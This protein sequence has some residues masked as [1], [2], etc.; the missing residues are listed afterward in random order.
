MMFF[1]SYRKKLGVLFLLIALVP[2][3]LFGVS[4]NNKVNKH[5]I[6][7][8]ITVKT[9]SV[10]NEAEKLDIW[11][12]INEEKIKD[13]SGNYSFITHLVSYADNNEKVTAYLSSQLTSSKE[14]QN[15]HITMQNGTEYTSTGKLSE[16]D[17]RLSNWY[18]NAYLSKDIVWSVLDSGTS[19][20]KLIVTASVPLFDDI[21]EIE[22]VLAADFDFSVILNGIKDI[23]INKNSVTYIVD[24][25]N[26]PLKVFGKELPISKKDNDKFEKGI[27]KLSSQ[28]R[29][30]RNGNTN[31]ELG[32]EYLVFYS[33]LPSINWR[34]ISFVPKIDFYLSLMIIG[35]YIAI[36][37]II[38]ISIVIIMSIL[39]SKTFS[40]P[41]EKLKDGAIEIRN[42]NY[43]YRIDVENKDEFGDVAQAF[44][45]MALRLKQSYASLNDSNEALTRNNE[46]LQEI[47]LELEASYEQLK[48]TTD[49]LNDS[50]TKYRL[51]I[52]NMY[53]LVW[54]VDNELNITFINDQVYNIFKLQ[55]NEVLGKKLI[56]F[57][58]LYV[59]YNGNLEDD[60]KKKDY[61]NKEITVLDKHGK[62]V[63]AEITT[64]RMQEY[65]NFI[66]VQGVVRDITERKS[67]E[68]NILKRNEELSVINKISRSISS[69][70]NAERLLQIAADD[71]ARL[72]NISV[73]TIRLVSEHNALKLMAHSGELADLVSF[74]DIPI[75]EDISGEVVKTG[76]ILISDVRDPKTK[77]KHNRK[78]IESNKIYFTSMLPIKSR[79]KV[80]GVINVGGINKLAKS[81]F[82]ILASITNQIAMK[83]ENIQLYEGLKD[84]YFKTIETLAAAIEAKDEYTQGHSSRV[85]RYSIMI[86]ESLGLSK[87]YCE[88]IEVAGI[89]HDIGKIGIS[90]DIL[91][92]PGRL[93]EYE[94][95]MITKHPMI[96]SKILENVG[97]SE[98]IM[99]AIKYH[100]R[101]YDLKGYPKQIELEELPLEACIVGVSDA[102]D[103]MTSNRSYRAAMTVDNAIE[104]L[105]KNRG[106]QFH[107]YIVD[108]IAEIYKTDPN[109]LKEIMSYETMVS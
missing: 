9:D 36:I 41:L 28:I 47:N 78:V 50:E 24:N 81:E 35:K 38:T 22:G 63:V 91:S 107:P 5:I 74:Q 17:T 93:T 18:L 46:Q 15:I 67:M 51:L 101:R 109:K 34:I 71:I 73:C 25:F 59:G 72:L 26:N 84:N 97:F 52:E 14:I 13:I 64:K 102:F 92:K 89:L 75:D 68:R 87:K 60:L 57:A 69:T 43:E 31:I 39:F 3:L 8:N 95:S 77:N 6:S 66:G 53:D 82:N 30:N 10:I 45:D 76:K 94:Y 62:Q 48:A 61:K 99:N 1:N 108:I 86:A 56:D 44:N 79:G 54:V 16:E 83:I 85:S 55:K 19:E 11:F 65:D 103:A 4:I 37:S 105:I 29:K 12:K 23:N 49:Q 106:T 90:D 58:H 98:T 33:T 32:R 7:D 40:R 88:E 21:G 80:L 42:G 20:D 104:E 96:G 2:I 27:G 100:H 70:M